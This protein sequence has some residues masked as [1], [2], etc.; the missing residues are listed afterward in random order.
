ME[1]ICYR[2]HGH[3]EGDEPFFTQ[4]LMY[5]KIKNR[6]PA[7]EIYARRLEEQGLERS[8]IDTMAG[9]IQ[10]RL[11]KAL[12]EAGTTPESYNFV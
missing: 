3:N 6:P 2:R 4:P 10:Q 8:R 1:I 9:A 5:E 7:H 11:E 12:G